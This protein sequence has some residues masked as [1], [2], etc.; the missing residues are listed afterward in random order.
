[1]TVDWIFRETQNS[2]TWDYLESHTIG[3]YIV[4]FSAHDNSTTVYRNCWFVWDQEESWQHARSASMCNHVRSWSYHETHHGH[5]D[6]YIL[7]CTYSHLSSTTLPT[8][9][10]VQFWGEKTVFSPLFRIWRLRDH[11]LKGN[12]G[13][14]TTRRLSGPGEPGISIVVSVHR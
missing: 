12:R 10:T 4:Y 3:W 11:G 1:M 14:G 5:T 8:R 6:T 2:L 13:S 7:Y 9:S